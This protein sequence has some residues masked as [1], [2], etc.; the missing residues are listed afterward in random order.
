MRARHIFPNP[1]SVGHSNQVW[2][3]ILD[4]NTIDQFCCVAAIESNVQIV[5]SESQF[6]IAHSFSPHACASSVKCRW[7][8]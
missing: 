6:S 8:K 2:S 5:G 3:I 7:A 4:A 1:E